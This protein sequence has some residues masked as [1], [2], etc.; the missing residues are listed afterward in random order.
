MFAEVKELNHA[1]TCKMLLNT[2]AHWAD[3]VSLNDTQATHEAV[4][5]IHTLQLHLHR[6]TKGTK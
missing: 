1:D 4:L 2:E 3:A 6:L 5:L